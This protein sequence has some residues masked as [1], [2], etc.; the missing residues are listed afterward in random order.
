LLPRVRDAISFPG[1]TRVEHGTLGTE[2]ALHG[3]LHLA[4]EHARAAAVAV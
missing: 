3:A 1:P 2:A 4:L